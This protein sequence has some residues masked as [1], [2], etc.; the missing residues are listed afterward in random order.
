MRP[1]PRLH[2][3][4]N[5]ANVRDENHEGTISS[6]HGHSLYEMICIRL[7]LNGK[8]D[9]RVILVYVPLML[10]VNYPDKMKRE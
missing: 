8:L 5:F 1:N 10:D 7:F 9:Q 6:T 2:P 3:V 4:C